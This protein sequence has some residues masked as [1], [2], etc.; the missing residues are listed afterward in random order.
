MKISELSPDLRASPHVDSEALNP[1]P[2]LLGELET[3]VADAESLSSSDPSSAEALAAALRRSLARLSSSSS[4]SSSSAAPL[5]EHAKLQIWKL[6]F[7]LWNACV[8]LSNSSA[9]RRPGGVSGGEDRRSRTDQAQVRQAAAELLLLAG[10]PSGVP[11][12]AAKAAS[13]FHRTGLIWHELGRLDLAAACFERATDLVSGGG[14]GGAVAGEEERGLVLEINLARARTAWEAS[15][16]G[17]AVALLNRSKSLI[18]GSSL[19]WFKTLAEEY[20]RFGRHELSKKPSGGAPDAS[21]LFSEALDLCEKGIAAAPSETLDLEGLK[22]RCLRFMAAERLQAEDYEGVLRCVRV[23]RAA[24]GKG[25]GKGK[26]KG[27][28]PSVGYVAMRAWLGAGR[29]GEAERELKG[30]V[31]NEEAPEGVCVSAAEAY[32]ATA[33]PEAARGVLV[34]LAGRCSAGAGA[35]LRIVKRVAEGGGGLGRARVVAELSSDERVVALFDS[36]AATSKE[37]GAM[38]ALLWNCGAEHFRSKDYEMSAELFESSML[39]VPRDEENRSRRSNCFR[40]LCLCH[41]ALSHL[42]RAREFIDEANKLEPNIKC[43]FLKRKE[44]KEAINQMQSMVSCVDFNPEFLTLS[45]HEAIASH[46]IPVA[47]ASLS[48]LLNLYSPG[49]PMPMPEVAVL[50]NLITLLQRNPETELEVLKYSR[51]ASARMA[52]LGPES[53]F[54]KGAVG[55]RE[56]SWFA[57]NSWNMGLRTG[58]EKKLE[59]CSEFLELAAE[60]YNTTTDD[61]GNQSMVCKSL[62]LSVGATLNVE[63]Q[64][65]APLL[66]QDVKKAIDMLT[67]AGKLLPSLSSS[68]SHIGDQSAENSAFSFLHTYYSYQLCSR[69]DHVDSHT[70]QLQLIKTF[71]ATKPCL[72]RHLLQLGLAASQGARPNPEAAEFSLNAALSAFLASPSPEYQS[73]GIALRKLACLAGYGD[74]NDRAYDVYRQ[75]Y[76][77][78]VGLKDGEYPIEEGKWLAMTAWNKAGFAVRLRQVNVARKWM[79][80]GLDLARHLKGMEQYIAGMEECFASFEKQCGNEDGKVE[81]TEIGSKSQPVLV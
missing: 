53:F 67:R 76:Q 44:E 23:L 9:V 56:L 1:L 63:E 22:E 30:L 19:T 80:M 74:G 61:N 47:V 17:L 65:N 13:F 24:A 59:C 38:H 35:A 57:G 28:H 75:A 20:L 7:R 50:R 66:E 26:G 32:L 25:K 68:P 73:I 16:R 3:L 18:H 72:P 49:K 10:C 45:A 79:K 54:G 11:S 60:F 5:P 43:A 34:A 51:R 69:I 8:D 77:I 37:R 39:Y 21:D 40:V 48:V 52:E 64:K 41:L 36:A 15:D 46:C 71:A 4:S 42:D 33:G 14:G 6:S 55:N 27:E 12:A 81:G 58:K 70:Q 29:V 62:I 78:I 2:L 31:A